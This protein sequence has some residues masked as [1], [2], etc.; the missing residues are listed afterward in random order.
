MLCFRTIQ[1]SFLFS[2]SFIIVS[3]V[4]MKRSMKWK[5]LW[6]KLRHFVWLKLSLKEPHLQA[7]RCPF[8]E[9][10]SFH[11][12]GLVGTMWENRAEPQVWQ[13]NTAKH[14][15]A[16]TKKSWWQKEPILRK[17]TALWHFSHSFVFET[18]TSRP[19]NEKG[20]FPKCYFYNPPASWTSAAPFI[21]NQYG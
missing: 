16:N 6:Q 10:V 14:L 13:I 3:Y 11:A 20:H 17:V 18:E 19:G 1:I 2:S 15:S 12:I 4:V 7:Q 21:W 5:G 9:N 8:C